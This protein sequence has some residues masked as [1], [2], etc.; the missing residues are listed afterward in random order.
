MFVQRC[1]D[2]VA[3]ARMAAMDQA[4]AQLSAQGKC[5]ARIMALLATGEA[6][7]HAI[8]RA[9]QAF[10]RNVRETVLRDLVESGVVLCFKTETDGR[11]RTTY[12]AASGD[13]SP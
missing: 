11:P 6:T 7:Q 2:Y 1:A 9:T 10:P 5:T 12:M 8:T 13:V 3:P 4:E